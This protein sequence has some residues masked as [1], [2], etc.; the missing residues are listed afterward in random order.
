VAAISNGKPRPHKER[1]W[2]ARIP[3]TDLTVIVTDADP[4]ALRCRLGSQPD[5][6]VLA[7]AVV[8]WTTGTVLKCPV[9][10]LPAPG[11]LSVRDV[12]VTTRMG[13]TVRYLIPRFTPS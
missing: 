10:D 7:V 6:G 8:P 1:Q 3:E 5:S 4:A 11:T 12:R 13:R 2:H 9:T